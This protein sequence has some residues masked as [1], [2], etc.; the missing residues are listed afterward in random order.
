MSLCFHTDVVDPWSFLSHVR[1]QAASS[2]T[3][4]L[5]SR[6]TADMEIISTVIL[7]FDS[8]NDSIHATV[9]RGSET[10]IV[11]VNAKV[12]SFENGTDLKLEIEGHRLTSTVVRENDNLL[13]VFLD[14]I[15]PAI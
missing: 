6:V 7:R 15:L 2:R 13:H 4:V 14:V 12:A 5:K 3:V 8:Q 1:L 9:Q 11:F 10:P